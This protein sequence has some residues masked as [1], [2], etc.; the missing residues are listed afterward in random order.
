M[1]DKM[2]A[3]ISAAVHAVGPAGKIILYTQNG[4]SQFF[5]QRFVR[6]K[7]KYI[8]VRSQLYGQVLLPDIP[9]E[10]F[11]VNNSAEA[12]CNINCLVGGK[13]VQYNDL[14]SYF[15]H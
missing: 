10:F 1:P 3:I 11:L 6:I 15:F 9:P 12:A 5:I 13:G 8:V 7:T 4:C 14:I 2:A